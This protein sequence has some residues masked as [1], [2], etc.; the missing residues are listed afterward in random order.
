M[1]AE[2][3]EAFIVLWIYIANPE[4]L[5]TVFQIWSIGI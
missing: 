5:L 4:R 1:V 3:R 2:T